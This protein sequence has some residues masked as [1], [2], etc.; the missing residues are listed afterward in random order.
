MI[1]VVSVVVLTLLPSVRSTSWRRLN[2]PPSHAPRSSPSC[3][4]SFPLGRPL[5][6]P[7]LPLSQ[8]LKQVSPD[9][10][11]RPTRP[12]TRPA[13]PP[14]RT[15]PQ[16]QE[17]SR[18]SRKGSPSRGARRGGL[19]PELE[20]AEW[21]LRGARSR[22]LVRRRRTNGGSRPFAAIMDMHLV[23]VLDFATLTRLLADGDP[24]LVFSPS[25]SLSI[26]LW[27]ARSAKISCPF[28][29]LSINKLNP[30]K[31]KPVGYASDHRGNSIRFVKGAPYLDVIVAR[32]GNDHELLLCLARFASSVAPILRP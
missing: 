19:E 20:R 12:P 16:P 2:L 4:P 32:R 25:L 8:C 18:P 29:C 23:F 27:I 10:S 3:P 6:R 21:Q 26:S 15:R 5:D 31:T 11:D 30:T 28:L 1:V 24:G 17:H 13:T 7:A 14:H 22:T 9:P